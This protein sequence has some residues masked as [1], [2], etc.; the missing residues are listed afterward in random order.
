MKRKAHAADLS[1]ADLYSLKNGNTTLLAEDILD[2]DIHF[3]MMEPFQL[4]RSIQKIL[5]M[6]WLSFHLREKKRFSEIVLQAMSADKT[7]ISFIFPEISF[8]STMER[9]L[10]YLRQE[11]IISG[12]LIRWNIVLACLDMTMTTTCGINICN[13]KRKINGFNTF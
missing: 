10:L 9:K 11:R 7:Q 12:I 1:I 3:L 4:I 2:D 8:I 6:S 5:D 13:K